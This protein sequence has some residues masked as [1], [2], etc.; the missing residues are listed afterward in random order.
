MRCYY[1][2]LQVERSA[3][4]DELKKQYRRLA[5][6]WHPDKNP[7][8]VEEAT[9]IFREIQEAYDVLSDPQERAWYDGHRDS[10]LRGK[11]ISLFYP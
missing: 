6:Q 11:G 1:E 7:Q 9:R 8:N 10:I 2:I 4:S 5:L 3:D